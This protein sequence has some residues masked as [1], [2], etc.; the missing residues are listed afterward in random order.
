VNATV[1]DRG[2]AS[3]RARDAIRA[4]TRN[5]PAVVGA[6][7]VL[8]FL[9][10]ALLA[11]LIAP[12]DPLRGVMIDRLQRPSAA[13]LLGTD[14]LGR[15]LLS[16]ILFGARISLSVALGVVGG[17]M[18]IGC[19]L[20]L[21]AGLSGRLVD[22]LVMRLIDVLQAFPGLLLAIAIVSIL[23]PGL[24]NA[25]IAIGISRIPQFARLQRATVLV[26]RERQFVEASRAVG[27]NRV[28]LALRHVFPNTLAPL[29]VLATVD[30]GTAVLVTGTL[31][32]LGLGAVPPTPEWGAMLSDG[33]NLLLVAPH[34]V[35][36]PGVA[37]AAVVLGFNLLGD[38]IRDL[39]DP[40]TVRGG[41]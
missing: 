28:R 5:V 10:A 20:G 25:M 35:V 11:P 36:A 32:F 27:S 38:G 17:S 2:R 21:V 40:R 39:L 30:M 26:V 16:R 37:I 7:I 4:F 31:G 29:A 23:G 33:R 6:A 41:H 14:S 9:V 3:A 1:T 12:H 22:N 34:V 18:V 15:D 13:Y 24:T 8:V 19:L